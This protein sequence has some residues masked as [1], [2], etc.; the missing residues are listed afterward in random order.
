MTLVVKA[1][2]HG[3]E[4]NTIDIEYDVE[5]HDK[6]M[7]RCLLDFILGRFGFMY[8]FRNSFKMKVT[9]ANGNPP[10]ILNNAKSFITQKVENGDKIEILYYGTLHKENDHST[11]AS[12]LDAWKEFGIMD[13]KAFQIDSRPLS[14]GAAG[15]VYAASVKNITSGLSLV[16]LK[17]LRNYNPSDAKETESLLKELGIMKQCNHPTIMKLEGVIPPSAN[18]EYPA[19]VTR[20][21]DG[22]LQD[23]IDKR[24][25]LGTKTLSD[26]E[27]YLI[28]YGIAVGMKYLHDN[29][30]HHRDLK[31]ANVLLDSNMRPVITDFGFSKI[32]D[33]QQ[34]LEMSSI[35]GTYM[36]MAPEAFNRAYS[37]K[38]DVYAFAIL[39]WAVWNQRQ[40]F[41]E[42]P[43]IRHWNAIR[44]G[45]RPDPINRTDA[46][47]KVIG[48]ITERGWETLSA[49]RPD[50]RTIVKAM[51]S[52]DVLLSMSDEDRKMFEE[53]RDF[54][55]EFDDDDV[56]SSGGM[57]RSKSAD[58]IQSSDITDL[59]RR[60]QLE[61][62]PAMVEMGRTYEQ[63]TVIEQDMAKA[64]YYYRSAAAMDDAGGYLRLARCYL[65]GIGVTKDE[66]VGQA[67]LERGKEIQAKSQE[68]GT[69]N[70]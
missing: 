19:I 7:S 13:W 70:S 43:F 31:P 57:S 29:C 36:Y 39:A 58:P 44:R 46:M 4:E 63:G 51:N 40:P 69:Q 23:W 9:P 25:T 38:T 14:Q 50:F 16:A 17:I 27:K 62:G 28:I 37:V 22:S 48:E 60:A 66:V 32:S 21:M 67:L 2:M 53:Y 52:Q 10:F 56:R 35:G 8:D 59:E 30:I 33:A 24:N 54:L 41:A 18:R 47:A 6:D 5:D 45:E 12:R 15:I 64:V 55:A 49:D 1:F 42:R 20:L 68:Q 3:A 11:D 61:D 65:N 34:S 26:A